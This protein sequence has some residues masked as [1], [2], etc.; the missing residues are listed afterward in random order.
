MSRFFSSWGCYPK[1]VPEQIVACQ[2]ISDPFPRTE[3][4]CLPYGLGRSYGDG[5]QNNGATLLHT[6]GFNRFRSF[7]PLTGVL[8]C[9]AGVSLEQIVKWMVP[10]GWFLPVTPG[11]KHVTVGG[12]IANDVHG[13]NHHTAGTFGCWVKHFE[14]LRSD[15]QR[16]P[17]SSTENAELFQATIG[18]LGLTGLITWADIQLKKIES[19]FID[20]GSIRFERL[21]DF[22][23]LSAASD[24]EFEYTVAWIDSS[25]NGSSIGRG[26]FLRGNHAPISSSKEQKKSSHSILSVPFFFPN[27]T[28]NAISVGL[29]NAAYYAKQWTR[30][31]RS[32]VHYDPF[33]YPLDGV[34]HWNRVYGKFG[35]LQ[36][37]CVLPTVFGSVGI[38]EILERCAAFGS[39]SFLSV[40]K[41]FGNKPSPGFLSFPMEGVTLAMDFRFQGEKTLRLFQ[42][43]DTVVARANGRLYPAKDARMPRE[44]FQRGYPRLNE[45]IP[46]IDPRFSSSFWR[47]VK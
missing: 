2:W 14:L 36:Y 23:A 41:L 33:F 13:K 46:H 43:L 16:F 11:T 38:K 17:C 26:L 35:F 47:R 12:A 3:F 45:F 25:A 30:E 31:K 10:R 20:R 8:S 18:G 6:A 28:V 9:E 34:A 1:A 27:R 7:D 15:G 19:P 21:E 40:L 29:F 39:T 37:Q 5:C 22:F 44:L 24:R 32:F 42:E 4:A